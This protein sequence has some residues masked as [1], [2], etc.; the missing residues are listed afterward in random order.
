M[1]KKPYSDNICIVFET[2]WSTPKIAFFLQTVFDQRT[3]KGSKESCFLARNK[4]LCCASLNPRGGHVSVTTR[5]GAVAAYSVLYLP[6]SPISLT[7]LQTRIGQPCT[8]RLTSASTKTTPVFFFWLPSPFISMLLWLLLLEILIW[9][10][11]SSCKECWIVGPAHDRDCGVHC[12][13]FT[14]FA[15]MVYKCT[16]PRD[17]WL[18]GLILCASIWESEN[19]CDRGPG[20]KSHCK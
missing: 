18:R 15:W 4:W 7:E 20:L 19:M 2:D 13:L 5:E 8:R 9:E 16:S 14:N 17:G 10:W 11:I 6:I 12:F 3:S 1:H